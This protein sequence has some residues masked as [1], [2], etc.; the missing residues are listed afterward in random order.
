VTHANPEDLARALAFALRYDGGKRFRIGDEFMAN[1]AA[2]RI[3]DYLA[4]SGY[5]VMKKPPIGGH[6]QIAAAPGD[7]R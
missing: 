2:R 6:S 4:V 7:P 5:V 3:I 1:I